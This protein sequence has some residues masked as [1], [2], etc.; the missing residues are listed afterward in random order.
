[1]AR[2]WYG[3]EDEPFS[4][5]SLDCRTELV[6]GSE[7]GERG[8]SQVALDR[9]SAGLDM[10]ERDAPVPPIE[11]CVPERSVGRGRDE[12]DDAAGRAVRTFEEVWDRQA[13]VVRM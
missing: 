13:I 5:L 4:P 8:G 2:V 7:S 9:L 12:D 6:Q 3:R 1:M 11:G 10:L